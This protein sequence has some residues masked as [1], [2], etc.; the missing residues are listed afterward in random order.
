MND[1]AKTTAFLAI[2]AAL[3]GTA[4]WASVSRTNSV[5]DFRDVGQPFFREFTDPSIC[6]SLEV[7]ELDPTTAQPRE[8]TVKQQAGRW[9][10]PSHFDYPADAKDRLAQTAAQVIGLTKDTIRSSRSEDHALLGVLDPREAKV[11]DIDGV[12]R[13]ITL[14]DAS[15][16][17]LADYIL[18]KLVPH[19]PKQRYVRR[20][21]QVRTYGVNVEVEPSTRFGDWIE[22]N[23]LGLEGSSVRRV[24]F[25][26]SK[27]DPDFRRFT[28]VPLL[29]VTR[30]GGSAPW[31]MHDLAPEE[32]VDTAKAAGMIQALADLKIVGVR[33]KTKVLMDFLNNSQG[34]AIDRQSLLSLISYGFRVDQERHLTPDEG[35]V[36]VACADGISYSLRFGKVTFARGEALTAGVA[37]EVAKGEADPAPPAKE[38]S[39]GAD[40]A[41]SIESRF[42]FV[43]AAFDP[44]SL[45][46]PKSTTTVPRAGELPTNVFQRTSTEIEGVRRAE[47]AAIEEWRRRIESGRLRAE[48]LTK[49]FSPWYFVVPGNDYR[50]ILLDRRSLVRNKPAPGSEPPRSMLPGSGFKPPPRPQTRPSGP[51][52]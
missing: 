1:T 35:S 7:F 45:A 8:F 14:R 21:G 4:V 46:Q 11:A 51:G 48:T 52:H 23:L 17:V 10:I 27:W 19:H 13:R 32:E 9:V 40:A 50:A 47:L 3:L 6:T 12:G 43:T 16:R 34:R 30:E 5:D 20:P 29:T 31:T 25:D 49:R 44:T 15:N 41:G 36:K 37:D 24:T 39:S 33:P 26:N 2:S 42:L 18:G 28:A 22:P 38:N